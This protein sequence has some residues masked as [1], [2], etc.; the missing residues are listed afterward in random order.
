MRNQFH[1]REEEFARP[2][3]SLRAFRDLLPNAR[4]FGADLDANVL[5]REERIE[6]AW[7][8]QLEPTTVEAL[9]G[10]FG[11][12]PFDLFIDDGLHAVA[13]NLVTLNFALRHVR[14]G[15]F[16]VI[17]DITV[18]LTRPG[19]P[20]TLIDSIISRDPSLERVMVRCGRTG[21]GTRLYVV[22]KSC[23]SAYVS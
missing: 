5:F 7:V 19:G 16:I 1:K 4:V 13:P 3:A 22:H 8:N 21:R 12:E 15:G 10:R 20:W 14:P 11:S 18:D 23:T 6:T 17:E 9:Y 2:G